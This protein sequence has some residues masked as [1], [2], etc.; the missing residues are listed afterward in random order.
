MEMDQTAPLRCVVCTN[1]QA[2]A[3]AGRKL[4]FRRRDHQKPPVASYNIYRSTQSGGPYEKVASGLTGKSFA[5]RQ[6]EPVL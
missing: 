1:V 4:S 6:R 2:F 5:R 3:V